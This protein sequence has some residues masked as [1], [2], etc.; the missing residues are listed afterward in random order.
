LSTIGL[1]KPYYAKITE[2]EQG[3]ETYGPPILLAKAIQADLAIELAEAILYADDTAAEVVKEFKKGTLSLAID[4]LSSVVASDL[5]GASIDD[6]KVLVS[7]SEDGG[8]PVAIGFRAKKANGRYRYFWLYRVKFGIP[9]TNLQTKGDSITF[10]NPT[11]EGTIYR[12]NRADSK[13]NH[14]W[15]SEV[16]E[17]DANVPENIINSWFTS[18]YEP[19]FSNVVISITAQ[20][21]DAETTEGTGA[22]LSV[23]ATTSSGALTYQWYS[24]TVNANVGGTAINGATSATY[25]TPADADEG[26]YYYYCIVSVGSK[27]VTSNVV[28]VTVS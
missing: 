7:A 10:K 18:V 19:A 11:I 8:D 28:E 22:E 25:T 26:S 16:T 17:G 20:P 1:D 14:P 27:S 21:Q 12:R 13:G 23:T 6:N 4:D 3:N 15:K 9:A 24:N 5:T 2:D